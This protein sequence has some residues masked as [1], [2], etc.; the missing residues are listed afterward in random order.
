MV[1]YWLWLATRAG[2]GLRK[3]HLLL[4]HFLTP[5]QVWLADET[6]LR[7]VEG[8]GKVPSLED[9][10]LDGADKILNDCF[11]KD[12]QV[13]T[14]QDAVYPERLR[15]LDD[16]PLVLYCRGTMPDFDALPVIAKPPATG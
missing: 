1:R 2:I 8:L 3:M 10:K 14:M 11:Q 13:I 16:A 6:A 15:N 9:K 4:R 5:E 12:I 7:R